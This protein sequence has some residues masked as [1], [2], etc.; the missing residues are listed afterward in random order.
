MIDSAYIGTAH[1]GN[2]YI[3]L[4]GEHIHRIRVA[5]TEGASI[6]IEEAD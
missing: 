6:K 4:V 5:L 3:G 2:F 1:I